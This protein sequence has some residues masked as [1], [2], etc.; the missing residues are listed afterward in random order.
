MN[1]IRYKALALRVKGYSYNE[2]KQKL[3]VP[4]STLSSWFSEL[5]L[6]DFAKKRLQSRVKEGTLNGLVK[7]NILQTQLA[8]Q[9]AKE[10][11]LKA[12]K[13]I[14]KISKNDLLL[15]G[16]TL[17]WAEGYKRLKIVKGKER[18]HHAISL[19]NSDPLIVV[20]FIKFLKEILGVLPEKI[21][22]S[23]RLFAHMNEDEAIFYW[24]KVTG[25]P[26]SQFKKPQYPISKSSLGKRPYN[27]LPY[28]TVQVIVSDTNKFH[29]IM[30][31]IEG[32]Q[33]NIKMPR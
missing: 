22:M 15:L 23:M 18:T 21:S 13:E 28:G 5:I 17:Y 32:I 9:R 7:R 4:K 31:F 6:S 1:E 25:L 29:K 16:T 24:H 14:N 10:I 27:R 11:R 12:E 20:T 33:N 2:I 30:G 19:T 3:G 26:K 8:Q